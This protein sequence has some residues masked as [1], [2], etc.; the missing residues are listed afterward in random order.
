[1]ANMPDQWYI[2]EARKLQ[3]ERGK[4]LGDAAVE[5]ARD[6]EVSKGSNPGAWVSAWI[7]V[8]DPGTDKKEHHVQESEPTGADQAPRPPA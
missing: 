4:A 1:M 6:P 8:P 5:V 3:K 7:W 2:D